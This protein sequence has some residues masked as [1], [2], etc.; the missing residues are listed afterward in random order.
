MRSKAFGLMVVSG[1]VVLLAYSLVESGV[2]GISLFCFLPIVAGGLGAWMV[3]ARTGEGAV[4]A[5]A[6]TAF[7]GSAGFLLI[8]WEGDQ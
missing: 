2:Y 3:E 5:G 8:G 1:G 4:A 7:M 6:A